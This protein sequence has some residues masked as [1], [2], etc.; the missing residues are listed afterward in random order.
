MRFSR[1]SRRMN[2]MVYD[3]TRWQKRLRKMGCWSESEARQNMEILR[4]GAGP[5]GKRRQSSID[6]KMV[7]GKGRPE[8]MVNGQRRKPSLVGS[9]QKIRPDD[10]FDTINIGAVKATQQPVVSQKDSALAVLASVQSIRGRA[11]QQ[12]GKVYHTLAPFYKDALANPST[13]ALIFRAYSLP[14]QQARMLSQIRQFSQSDFS[15]GGDYR[16]R[17]LNEM[18]TMFN[19]AA[20]LEFRKGYEYKDIQGRMKQYAHVMHILDGGQNGVDLY[21]NDNRLIAEKNRLGTVSDCIDYSLGYGELSLERVQAYFERLGS[22]YAQEAA[23]IQ[24]VFPQSDEVS[25]LFLQKVADEVLAPFLSALFADARTRS[26]SMYLRVISGTF[27][28]V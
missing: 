19:T 22:A 11:R 3:D 9:P 26:T 25:L 17:R 16:E 6:N 18:V 27:A 20:L 1:V 21:L 23:I 10:G 2:E 28:A 4:D 24:T 13:T 8:I 12:Y 5:V 15:P 14:E 7:N